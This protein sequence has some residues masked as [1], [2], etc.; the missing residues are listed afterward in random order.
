[1]DDTHKTKTRAENP[2]AAT[3]PE[4]NE[5]APENRLHDLLRPQ[6][7]AAFDRAAFEREGYWVWEGILT[8]AGRKQWTASLQRLQQM[9]DDIVMDTD[10]AAIDYAAHGME[11]PP[12]E[13]LTPEFKATC[14]GGS[15][16]Q[17]FL[18]A[19]GRPYMHDHGL[20]GPGP[21]LVTRDFE[22]QGFLPEYFPA[23]YDDFILDISSAHP[24]MMELLGKLLGDRFVLD[25]LILLNRAPATRGRRWHGHQYRD[26]QYEVE[27]FIGDGHALTT[28]FLQQQCIRTLCYPQG[29]N[30]E[31]GGEL[32]LIP[33]A[34]LYRIPY[35]WNIER[36]D[37]H[38]E[39]KAGWLQGKIHAST[40]EPLEILQL[41]IPPGSMVSF[42]HHMP[43]YVGYR[44]PDA[45]TR[46]GLL[47]A[48]RTPDPEASPAR[49]SSGVAAHWADRTAA[50]GKLS[51][52]ARRVFAA[53]NPLA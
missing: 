33:G 32:A 47:M 42:V 17:Y 39:M 34:H 19:N 29:A 27:G 8:D 38:A 35:K 13:K 53:E 26:G 36:T 46:W 50:A 45:P 25:H 7:L 52:A 23:A 14:C 18:P 2:P 21:A 15:E 5:G 12:P 4:T 24:Q 49:W 44:Q 1:M 48:Y 9:N 43:H 30:I 10:W 40:G 16:Q 51:P 31:E 20:F 37:G 28:K 6:V 41:K 11:P 3:D 22:S